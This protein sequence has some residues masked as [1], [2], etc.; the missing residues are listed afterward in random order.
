MGRVVPDRLYADAHHEH[1]AAYTYDIFAAGPIAHCWGISY[2]SDRQPNK[3][4]KFAPSLEHRVAI[5]DRIVLTYNVCAQIDSTTLGGGVV[6]VDLLERANKLL[7]GLLGTNLLVKEFLEESTFEVELA[8]E[9]A[10][11]VTST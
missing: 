1:L 5:R 3:L 2:G 10:A 6:P 8:R 4:P 11:T 7:D 9:Q